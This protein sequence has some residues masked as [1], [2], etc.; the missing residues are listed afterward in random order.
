MK[1]LMGPVLSFKGYDS[2]NNRWKLSALVVTGS[3]EPTGIFFT[4][5]QN[6]TQHGSKLL[7][8]NGNRFAHSFQFEVPLANTPSK[9]T[10]SV[11]NG[12]YHD[13]HLPAQNDAPNMSYASC[14]GFS[15]QK[16]MK[17]VEVKNRMWLEMA[18]RHSKNPIH[19]M[20]LGG[21][22]VYADSIWEVVP[23]I[24]EWNNKPNQAA[25]KASFTKPMEK[26]VEAFYFN[27]YTERW[28]QPEIRQMMASIPSIAIWDDHDIFDGWGSYP[29]AR[30]DCPVFQ[31]IGAIATK[32]F[33]VFQQHIAPG[34]NKPDVYLAPTFGFSMG[35]VI[36]DTA[37][38]CLD[39][40]SERTQRQVL[41]NPHWKQVYDWVSGLSDIKH[42]F[43]MSSI[44]VVYPDFNVLESLLG[45]VPGQ[46]EL[47]DDLQ[48]HWSSRSHKGERTRMVHRLFDFQKTGMRVTILSGDVHVAALGILQN[49]R[50]EYEGKTRVINQLISSAIVHPAPSKMVLFALRH[51]LD[52]DQEIDPGIQSRMANLPGTDVRFV[53]ARNFLCLEPDDKNGQNRYWAHWIAEGQEEPFTKVIHPVP[54]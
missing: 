17:G 3:A 16:V 7:S 46:Q 36:G 8:Q 37:I 53:G 1:I 32:A 44:P 49:D 27:L 5:G 35:H 48:D 13:I 38:L 39:M 4:N 9:L 15:S 14:N 31:G 20:L 25:N 28:A 24:K 34:A 33:S 11:E 23:S 30:Q 12:I 26:Q 41:S 2:T 47:E 22:Q 51:L 52:N 54:S 6:V 19:L 40:R 18:E 29:P 10:Y 21:D 45:V 50:M 42:L 43:V